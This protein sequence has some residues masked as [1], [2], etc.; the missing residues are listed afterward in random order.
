M[1]TLVKTQRSYT[2][3]WTGKNY[4]M[5]QYSDSHVNILVNE[6]TG[7]K[8]RGFICAAFNSITYKFWDKSEI[9]LSVGQFL[10][11]DKMNPPIAKKFTGIQKR[12]SKL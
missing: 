11:Y 1:D 10:E 2:E 7:D 6:I 12:F 3:F 8:I 5:F 4:A 9:T